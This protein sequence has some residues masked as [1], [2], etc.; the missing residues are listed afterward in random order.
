MPKGTT[1]YDITLDA[2]LHNITYSDILISFEVKC[3]NFQKII[4]SI[5]QILGP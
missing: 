5:K 1:F 3:L 4:S 2:L